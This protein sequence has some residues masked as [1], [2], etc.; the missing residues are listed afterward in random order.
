MLKHIA[1]ERG[2]ALVT[3]LL[4]VVLIFILISAMLAVSGNEAIVASLQRDSVQAE[5]LAQ[6]GI[7]EGI[8]RV[9]NG[10]YSAQFTSAVPCPTT[11]T[12]CGAGWP[13][14]TVTV[15]R[16]Y[17][18]TNAGYLQIDATATAGRA[19][20]HLTALVLQQ[21]IAFPP[22]I[23]FAA[24]VASNG[25]ASISCGDVYSSSFIQYK[26]YPTNSAPGC[27]NPPPITY[28]GWQMS[29]VAPGVVATCYTNG[30]A[31]PNGCVAANPGNADVA[32][33]W[34][35][36][37]VTV[38]ASS[39]AGQAIQTF[40]N[41]TDP[42]KPTCGGAGPQYN[43]TMPSGA[44]LQTEAAG[45]SVKIWGY[46]TDI[47]P[48]A[49]SQLVAGLFPCGLPYEWI[50]SPP[51]GQPGALS[52]PN[53]GVALTNGICADGV[54]LGC[55]WFKTIIFEQWFQNYWRFDQ[56]QLTPVKRGNGSGTQACVDAI[57]LSGNVQPD[58]LAYPQFGAVPPFP[59]TSTVMSNYDC[60]LYSPAGGTLNSFPQTGT[61][62]N[63]SPCTMTDL[64]TASNPGIFV[65]GCASGGSWTINGNL[66][67]YGTLVLNCNAVINGT[68]TYNGTII[69]NGQL[70]AG[71]GNVT[72]NGG[73]VA[74]S[75]LQLIGNITVN[76]GGT[77][78]SVPTGTSNVFGKA[79]WER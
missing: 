51:P 2:A 9:Q 74:L 71:T 10:R 52:D 23:T 13:G 1:R 77:V 75:T 41:L 43:G 45:G 39:S 28:A 36:T 24:S 70:Q 44:I 18:G 38:A 57:C 58:L 47:P 31:A 7:Q 79:W 25:A 32:R 56:I 78:T 59:D 14:V 30:G 37:R 61:K 65:M 15:T 35:G 34:P 3:V 50:S 42:T 21:V 72:V 64:G 27:T 54:T 17:I 69:V 53:T 6:A 49:Q 19:T 66:V 73:L 8:R 4:F 26:N 16:V 68:V 20:R 46:D 62:P 5:D 55:R 60:M 48:A 22:N 67:G 76:G 11:A 63:G 40:K 29:K 12:W 33:W